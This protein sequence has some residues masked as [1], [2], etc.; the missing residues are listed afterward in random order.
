[1]P[2]SASAAQEIT[3][4]LDTDSGIA[5]LGRDYE[6][7]KQKLLL[8][9]QLEYKD[10]AAKKK[11][12]KSHVHEEQLGLSLPIEE[13]VSV[14]ERLREERQREYNLFLQEQAQN[15]RAKKGAH[16]ATSKPEHQASDAVSI[17]SPGSAS[18][19][20]STQTS[21]P[22]HQRE[23]PASVK[24][25]AT[26][27]EAGDHRRS[28]DTRSPSSWRRRRWEVHQP[29]R[30]YS[31]EEELN[32]EED[33]EYDFIRRRRRGR[34][35]N[36]QE[37]KEEWGTPDHGQRRDLRDMKEMEALAVRDQN[38]SDRIRKA[39]ISQTPQNLKTTAKSTPTANKVEK[40]LATGLMIGAVE[41]RSVIHMKKEQYK[42]ELLKQM[43][44]QQKNKK[45]KKKSVLKL[46]AAE[47]TTPEKEE[48]GAASHQ[49]QSLDQDVSDTPGFDSK[50]DNFFESSQPRTLGHNPLM[51][52]GP[53]FNQL[54]GNTLPLYGMGAV[55]Q[56][57]S[58]F[59]YY[60]TFPGRQGQVAIPWVPVVPPGSHVVSNGDASRYE[61]PRKQDPYSNQYLNGTPGGAQQKETCETSQRSES[62][63]SYREAPRPQVTEKEGCTRREKEK[64]K[65]EAAQLESE[66]VVYDPWGKG[67]GG[68]PIRDKHGNLVSDLYQMR[69]FNNKR[70]TSLGA[71]LESPISLQE[72]SHPSP[73]Q[74]DRY[75]EE[76]RQQIEERKRKKAEERE[77]VRI[78]EENEEKKL[79][80]ERVRIQQQY[81]EEKRREKEMRSKGRQ[82]NQAETHDIEKVL[83]KEQKNLNAP[84]SV[85]QN[86]R[87]ES[88]SIPTLH[89]KC[90][91]AVTSPSSAVGPLTPRT[92]FLQREPSPPIPTLQR[93][94]TSLS[95]S[96]SSDMSSPTSR[97]ERIV[98]APSIQPVTER[99]PSIP[100]GQQEVIRELSTLRKF[101]RREQRHLELQLKE[102]AHNPHL[103]KH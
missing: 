21:T 67:G 93:K 6:K 35:T 62:T 57:V 89:R 44:E 38:S 48:I 72:S 61:G 69:S 53:N 50:C 59:N 33:E 76:L 42:Q 7:K 10:Y 87:R 46:G 41:E 60:N 32:T 17:I 8:E 14:K 52:F 84:Q 16:Q 86:E 15:R 55:Q 22:P 1:M 82:S 85:R 29:R 97:I 63:E 12:C 28:P 11:D 103:H 3:H 34:S 88:P 96:L 77:R 99:K 80:M 94:Q 31:S 45:R 79:A 54:P 47:A 90:T 70:M 65:R 43:A 27:T 71:E 39:D 81:E 73:L 91:N 37:C 40:E 13:K 49:H 18:S 64:K 75:T 24:N 5:A 56:V 101:L 9:L 30:T 68:A 98:S 83:S 74:L 36:E 19:F 78:A 92:L 4:N 23:S 58:P 66:L 25:A 20:I 102:E 100:A 26:L 51:N 95:P 2:P